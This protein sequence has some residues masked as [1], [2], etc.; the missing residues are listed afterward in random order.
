[1]HRN[2]ALSAD[3]DRATQACNA[4]QAELSR[5]QEE[6]QARLARAAWRPPPPTPPS[7]FMQDTKNAMVG[8]QQKFTAELQNADDAQKAIQLA[9]GRQQVRRSSAVC[10]LKNS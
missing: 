9:L 2:Q 10:V 5:V 6:L 4:K 3:V 1:M 8:L 7:C